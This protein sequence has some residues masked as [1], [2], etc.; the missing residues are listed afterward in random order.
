[1]KASCEQ[2]AGHAAQ[3]LA[4]HAGSIKKRFR[5]PDLALT[6]ETL[7]QVLPHYAAKLDSARVRCLFLSLVPVP[8]P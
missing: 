6:G 4:R 5:L 2:N 8:C 3:Q 1:M 7:S